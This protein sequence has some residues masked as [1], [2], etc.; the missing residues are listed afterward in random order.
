MVKTSTFEGFFHCVQVA[1]SEAGELKE[2]LKT[3]KAEYQTCQSRY[4]EERTRLE[5]DVTTLGEKL[6][7]LEKSSQ[8]DREEKAKLEK[9][10]RKVRGSLM[11]G[12]INI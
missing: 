7:S 1:V 9:E 5:N 12:I 2:E 6:A 4:D 11:M 10:L 8:I 3:L